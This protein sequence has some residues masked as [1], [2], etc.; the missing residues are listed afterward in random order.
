MYQFYEDSKAFAS[1]ALPLLNLFNLDFPF[2]SRVL[3]SEE[4]PLIMPSGLY[5]YQ[6]LELDNSC[7]LLISS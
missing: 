7:A 2:A 1:R 5:C 3:S 4:L 6:Y